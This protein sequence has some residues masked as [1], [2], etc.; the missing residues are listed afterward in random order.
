[1]GIELL[2]LQGAVMPG[3]ALTRLPRQPCAGCG[4]ATLDEDLE[5]LYAD[6]LELFC[7]TCCFDRQNR[8]DAQRD[9]EHYGD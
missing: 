5:A 9:S 4:D 2:H 6:K 7:P 8:A 1:V 3:V